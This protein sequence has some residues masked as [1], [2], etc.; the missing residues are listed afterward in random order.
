MDTQEGRGRGQKERRQRESAQLRGR[1]GDGAGSCLPP[2]LSR[3]PHWELMA[4]SYPV[5][6]EH[7]GALYLSEGELLS[8]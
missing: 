4:L 1:A 5:H 3:S 2:S 6:A 8:I 7:R